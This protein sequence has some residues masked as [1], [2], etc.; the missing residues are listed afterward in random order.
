MRLRALCALA[1][2]LGVAGP[3]SATVR[4]AFKDGKRIIYNDGIG[5]SSRAALGKGDGWLAARV[6]M[7]SYYDEAIVRCARA[8]SIDPKL[9]KSV[10]LIE[11][12]F[13]PRAVSRKGAR[14]L[15]QLMPETAERYGVHDLFNPDENISAG[16]RHLAYL[17][18]LYNGDT[19]RALAAYNAGEAA[20]AR[21]KG[22]PPYAETRLYVHKG[23]AAY[24]G[25]SSLGGGFGLP[26]EKSWGGAKGTRVIVTR[27]AKNRPL[28][29]ND[30]SPARS[31]KRG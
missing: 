27:D 2:L 28:L 17:L 19:T 30:S 6:A 3:A 9:V 12:A 1:V 7:P 20:V 24:G 5:E 26:Q 18:G 31:L 4:I 10:V 21:Y 16:T 29:T 23:L 13:D 8:S 14:G 25:R 15:M 22:I 11:S